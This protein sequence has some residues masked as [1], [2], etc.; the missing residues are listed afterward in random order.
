MRK[1]NNPSHG[2]PDLIDLMPL[3]ICG[4]LVVLT[5]KK[6]RKMQPFFNTL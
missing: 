4:L 1:I 5:Q 3:A 2:S 6:P